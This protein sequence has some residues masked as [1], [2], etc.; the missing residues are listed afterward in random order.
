MT[1]KCWVQL[2]I[3]SNSLLM[4][5]RSRN[6]IQW[7]WTRGWDL[8][9][10]TTTRQATMP[11]GSFWQAKLMTSDDFGIFWLIWLPIMTIAWTWWMSVMTFWW[12]WRPMV[13]TFLWPWQLLVKILRR[14][15]WAS[16]L[17]CDYFPWFHGQPMWQHWW[18]LK[19][20]WLWPTD[21]KG[22]QGD[23]EA[24]WQP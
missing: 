24:D 12:P 10:H 23:D 11:H 14:P 5:Y 22:Q 13:K 17:P 8:V 21:K 6:L 15:H 4:H 2:Y 19:L 16:W 7:L 20:T 1:C 18:P 3:L 9:V